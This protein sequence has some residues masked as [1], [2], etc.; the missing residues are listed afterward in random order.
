V[1]ILLVAPVE[2][3]SGETITA[4]HVGE[5][6][7]QRGHDVLFLA[8]PFAR[9]FLDGP[10]PGRVWTLGDDEGENHGT[11]LR[12]LRT[13]P[14]DAVV[15]AD[16][17]HLF[18]STGVSRLAGHAGWIESLDDLDA[19]LVT[20]DH[21][22]FAQR[23]MG[24]FFGPAHITTFQYTFFPA[25]PK[26]MQ[27]LL[28][29][30]MHEPGPVDD[31][32]GTPFRYWDVPIR[33]SETLRESIRRTYLAGDEML[34]VHSVPNWAWRAAEALR[35]PFYQYLPQLLG[36]FFGGS[37]RPITIVSVNNGSLLDQ[38][39]VPGMRIVNLGPLPTA[40]FEA[41]LFAADLVVTENK[42]SISMGKAICGFRTSAVLKNSYRL[43][44]LLAM[45]QPRVRDL[46]LA[47]ENFRPGSVYPFDVFP[48][49]FRDSL[50][51]LV[52][53]R[54]NSLT[55]GFEELEVFRVDETRSALQR[56]LFDQNARDAQETRQRQYVKRLARLG[57]AADT[58]E[59]MHREHR[60]IA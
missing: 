34:V 51:Q 7:A 10:F 37:R 30:P 43:P 31:R 26:R 44:E 14:P 18:F 57:N 17:P 22:G 5:T 59:Q 11:W 23:E 19:L 56:L 9:R 6:L 21:F 53:Y 35:L 42:V 8:A 25:I 41:L 38:A 2:Q 55:S 39:G 24:M 49:G 4:M 28:P 29:C 46:I 58:I 52:L 1:K 48:S 60:G 16:Y 15:F 50:E 3:G 32:R 47:M 45:V 36:E 33:I 27:I 13:F 54:D 40:E 20:F 12:A